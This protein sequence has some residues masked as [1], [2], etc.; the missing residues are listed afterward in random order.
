MNLGFLLDGG[1]FDPA[2][3]IFT[4]ITQESGDNGDARTWYNPVFDSVT[5]PQLL[6]PADNGGAF[7]FRAATDSDLSAVGISRPATSAMAVFAGG[8][9]G[10]FG[11]GVWF[12]TGPWPFIHTQANIRASTGYIYVYP[13]GFVN[14]NDGALRASPPY[15]GT[16]PYPSPLHTYSLSSNQVINDLQS[17]GEADFLMYSDGQV[18]MQLYSPDQYIDPVTYNIMNG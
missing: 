15:T 7:E 6:Y 2:V 13:H 10:H 3:D 18:D 16:P 11:S 4:G 9:S 17:Y 1:A 12:Y 14:K 8:G 5:P